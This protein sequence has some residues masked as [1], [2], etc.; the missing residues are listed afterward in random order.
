MRSALKILDRQGYFK[1]D[2]N[3]LQ[4]A[5]LI[6]LMETETEERIE[7]E[8]GRMDNNAIAANPVTNAEYLKQR[9]QEISKEEAEEIE[10]LTPENA[11]EIEK[12]LAHLF[13]SKPAN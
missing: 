10:W 7:L 9:M 13:P 5:S 6:H 11:D 1:G 8:R 12:T 3:Y 2:L 4:R